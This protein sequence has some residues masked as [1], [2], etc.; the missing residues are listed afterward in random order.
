MIADLVP[1]E[2]GLVRA[3]FVAPQQGRAPRQTSSSVARRGKP[4]AC[5][6]VRS[7]G[8]RT[9]GARS[10]IRGRVAAAASQAGPCGRNA[11]CEI[12]ARGRRERTPGPS[13]RARPAPARARTRRALDRSSRPGNLADR[14]PDGFHDFFEEHFDS[15]IDGGADG[16]SHVACHLR[17]KLK[18][19]L[20]GAERRV[21]I[22]GRSLDGVARMRSRCRRGRGGSGDPQR[23]M[24]HERRAER[25]ACGHL[26]L[27]LEYKEA[28]RR[29]LDFK[30]G[31]GGRGYSKRSVG[32]G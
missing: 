6:L 17:D 24:G 12:A 7:T 11:R 5:H 22:K 4:S 1:E 25:R 16:A 30:R 8:L 15:L 9:A 3:L 21:E 32:R 13:V 18:L 26:V 2:K 10:R 19:F 20:L 14:L 27:H 28:R 29:C 31:R 23:P